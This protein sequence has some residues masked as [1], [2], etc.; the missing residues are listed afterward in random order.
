MAFIE[1]IDDIDAEVPRRNIRERAFA[2]HGL[3]VFAA[4]RQL[5]AGRPGETWTRG[6]YKVV[7]RSAGGYGQPALEL[8]RRAGL[9]RRHS[10]ELRTCS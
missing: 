3:A 9:H 6:C 10:F 7:A 5:S 8:P 2:H 1:V 4:W